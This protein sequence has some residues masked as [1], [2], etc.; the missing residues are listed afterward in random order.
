MK[1]I[2]KYLLFLMIGIII[3]ILVN[4]KDNFSIGI[5]NYNIVWGASG[6][7]A[8]QISFNTLEEAEDFYREHHL[9]DTYP[10]M[11]IYRVDDDGQEYIEPPQPAVSDVGRFW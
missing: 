3:Y 11:E 8:G 2:L 5:E 10:N 1:Q 7:G 9:I 6:G 4:S